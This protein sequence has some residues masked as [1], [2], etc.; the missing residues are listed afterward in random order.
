MMSG[1][2]RYLNL[3]TRV[4]L[5]GLTV[6]QVCCERKKLS[7]WRQVKKIPETYVFNVTA[8]KEGRYNIKK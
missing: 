4:K 8:E 3:E 2:Y 7:F 6:E 5:G 1:E